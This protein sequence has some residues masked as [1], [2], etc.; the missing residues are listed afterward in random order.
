MLQLCILTINFAD[1]VK[2]FECYF[3]AFLNG[4]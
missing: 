1:I 4:I 2:V 3:T